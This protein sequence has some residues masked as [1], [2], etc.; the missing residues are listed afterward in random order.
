[1]LVEGSS[2][3][4]DRLQKLVLET[5]LFLEGV[6]VFV[7][8]LCPI[9]KTGLDCVPLKDNTANALAGQSVKSELLRQPAVGLNY[10]AR[11]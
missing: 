8:L 3:R 7:S 6:L 2:E 10:Y 4:L 11:D 1:M 9:R 5:F